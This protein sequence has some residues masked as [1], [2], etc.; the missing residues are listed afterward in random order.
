MV[1]SDENLN[2]YI[3]QM[4]MKGIKGEIANKKLDHFNLIETKWKTVKDY[5]PNAMV[6]F[7]NSS[8]KKS[9]KIKTIKKSNFAYRIINTAKATETIELFTLDYFSSSNTTTTTKNINHKITFI[10][11]K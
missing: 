8:K 9:N 5:F 10:I 2:F 11:G 6:F 1:P 7:H 4:L 3:S